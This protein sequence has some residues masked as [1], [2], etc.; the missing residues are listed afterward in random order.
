MLFLAVLLINFLVS[1]RSKKHLGMVKR[2][3][4]FNKGRFVSGQLGLSK[5]VRR[6]CNDDKPNAHH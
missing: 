5:D 1:V 6:K 4:R 2:T 3:D